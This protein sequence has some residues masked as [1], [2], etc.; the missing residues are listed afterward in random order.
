MTED[1]QAHFNLVG[2]ALLRKARVKAQAITLNGLLANL[3]GLGAI[4]DLTGGM[5][6]DIADWRVEEAD[7]DIAVG[8]DEKIA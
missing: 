2:Q 8:L 7:L 5:L 6:F 4:P 1:G 3:L